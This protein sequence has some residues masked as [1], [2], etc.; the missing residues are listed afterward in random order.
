M[1]TT[2]TTRSGRRTVTTAAMEGASSTV[3]ARRDTTI[4]LRLPEKVKNLIDAAAAAL[5]KTRTE[6]VIESAKQ[7]AIDVLLDRRL[8]ELDADQ[9]DA[10]MRALDNPPLPNEHLR[11]LMARKPPWER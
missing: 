2:T 7:D 1:R 8:F 11:K 3:K 9:W 5:G 4:N 10:F 6:F